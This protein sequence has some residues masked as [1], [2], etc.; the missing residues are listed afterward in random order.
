MA[1]NAGTVPA[2][3]YAGYFRPVSQP[4]NVEVLL[5]EA[6]NF[7]GCTTADSLACNKC[8]VF[9]RKLLQQCDED[10]RPPESIVHALRT[11]VD[12]L[13]DSFRQCSNITD[14][15]EVALLHTATYLGEHMLSDQAIT[16]PQL[17]QKYCEYLQSRLMGNAPPLPRYQVFVYMGKEFG[18]LMSSVSA[19]NRLGRVLY[20]AKCDPFLMLSH[21]LGTIKPQYEKEGSSIPPVEPVVEYSN[22]KVHDLAS[23]LMAEHEQKPVSANTFNLE[24]FASHVAPDLCNAVITLTQSCN[25]KLGRKQSD[26]HVYVRKVRIVYINSFLCM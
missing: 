7:D 1:T 13:Q 18:D 19:R 10:L 14:D 24:T 16:F 11:K 6:G 4:E 25:E 12:E 15:N 22:E 26:S 8:Y 17:Y 23:Q 5:C 3:T 2:V 20:R 9:C 21:A